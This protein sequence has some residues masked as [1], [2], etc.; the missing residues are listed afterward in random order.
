MPA[1]TALCGGQVI[2]AAVLILAVKA[3]QMEGVLCT[4]VHCEGGGYGRGRKSRR[5]RKE[6]TRQTHMTHDT[7]RNQS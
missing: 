4:T 3:G 7:G 2:E 5:K 6:I 1:V